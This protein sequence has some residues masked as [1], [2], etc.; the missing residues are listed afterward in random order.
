[1]IL[2]F[3]MPILF[4]TGRVITIG[5]GIA[6]FLIIGALFTIEFV[7]GYREWKQE[8]K[9]DEMFKQIE[10]FNNEFTRDQ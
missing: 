6:F 8:K 9:D 7:D 1:M 5:M 10:E 4:F 3:I 2:D